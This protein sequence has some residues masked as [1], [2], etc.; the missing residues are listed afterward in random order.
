MILLILL[1]ESSFYASGKRDLIEIH[2][3]FERREEMKKI[4]TEAV[5]KA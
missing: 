2:F 3:F 1:S 5:R 4:S